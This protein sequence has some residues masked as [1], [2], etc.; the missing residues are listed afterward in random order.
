HLLKQWLGNFFFFLSIL[1]WMP[2]CR[3]QEA[4]PK[5]SR[6][7]SRNQNQSGHRK[8]FQCARTVE[9]WTQKPCPAFLTAI[10]KNHVD[11]KNLAGKPGSL[12]LAVEA[13]LPWLWLCLGR[14]LIRQP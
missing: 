1:F 5:S 13:L 11:R 14:R 12:D 9:F 8:T 3:R 10:P 2:K 6:P 7:D 4:S